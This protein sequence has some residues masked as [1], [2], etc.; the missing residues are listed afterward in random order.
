[1]I[2]KYKTRFQLEVIN[3]V[4]AIRM[5]KGLSQEDIAIYLN[6]TRGYIGQVE[7][8]NSPSRYT[9]DQLNKLALEMQCS[10]RD[11]MPNEPIPL[12]DDVHAGKTTP[13]KSR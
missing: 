13:K 6:V 12:N 11:F 1:M 5:N 4:K 3:Q 7:S 2:K 10:P 8:I 9:L